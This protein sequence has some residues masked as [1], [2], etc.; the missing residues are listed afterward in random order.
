MSASKIKNLILLILALCAA[1]LACVALPKRAQAARQEKQLT[2]QVRTLLAR[3]EIT[4]E[5]QALPRS[6]PLYML[7]LSAEQTRA[8]QAL[9]GAQAEL[10]EDETGFT[11]T[12]HTQAGTLSFT[13]TGGF[14]AELTGRKAVRSETAQTRKLL[15]RMGFQAEKLRSA[16]QQTDGSICIQAEQALL[17]VPVFGSR[18]DFF[19]QDGRLLRIEGVFYSDQTLARVSDE[20]CISCA[21]ALNQLLVSR[22]ALGWVGGSIL[23]A[24][25]GYLPMETARSDI[26]LVPV[27]RL[28]TD[29]GSYTVNGITREVR[30][31]E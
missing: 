22:D 16:G 2:Q 14:S 7:E 6:A 19:Y 25:Q 5:E 4:L 8:A 12:Y 29:T 26:R 21:D 28:E 31:T 3:Y 13:R 20:I 24:Q 17:G 1:C 23:S 18:L 27:W 15:K 9:L 11:K 30:R 10:S